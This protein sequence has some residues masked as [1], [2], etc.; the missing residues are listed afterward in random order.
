M[1][2]GTGQTS[3]LTGTTAGNHAGFSGE[4]S[5]FGNTRDTVGSGN[6]SGLTGQNTTGLGN[7]QNTTSLGGTQNTQGTTTAGPHSSNLANKADPR[8]DSDL[9]GSR[10]A[11]NTSGV[12]NTSTGT[13]YG[14]SASTGTG[15]GSST[16]TYDNTTG[17]TGHQSSHL[18]RDAAVGAGGV[19]LAEQ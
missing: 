7:T 13:G 4:G 10:I 1:N 9:D 16:G 12:G 19:G 14:T 11:G 18:G 8:V 17:S 3:G 6:T 5:H 15:L 2:S